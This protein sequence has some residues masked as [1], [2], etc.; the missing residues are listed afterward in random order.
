MVPDRQTFSAGIAE[1]RPGDT[2]ATLIELADAALYR[3]K[4][5]GRARSVDARASASAAS[6]APAS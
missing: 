3:A 2:A 4:R 5:E 6:A 1:W